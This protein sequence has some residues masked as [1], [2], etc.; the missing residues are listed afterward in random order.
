MKHFLSVLDWDRES[1]LEL[2]ERAKR[3]VPIAKAATPKSGG[4]H[5]MTALIL[6]KSTRTGGSY[7]EAWELLGNRVEYISGEDK[8][9][10]G[11][12]ESFSHTARTKAGQGAKILTIRAEFEGIARWLAEMYGKYNYPT[13]VHNA[14]D[15]S[16]EH[17]SQ[18]FLDVLTILLRLGRLENFTIGIVGD[19]KNSRTV[20]SLVRMLSLFA[21]IRVVLVSAPEVRLQP[22]YTKGLANVE[23][24]ESLDALVGCDIVYVTRVQVERFANKFDY[25]KV[26]GRYVVDR[27]VLDMLGPD[28]LIMHPLPNVDG[29]IATEILDHPQV[30]VDEQAENGTPMRMAMLDWSLLRLSHPWMPPT[31]EPQERVLGSRS[32]RDALARKHGESRYFTPIETGTVVDHLDPAMYTTIR[33]VLKLDASST[34]VV[35]SERLSSSRLSGGRK[36]AIVLEHRFLEK[37]EKAAVTVLSPTATF[38][39]LRDGTIVKS[40]MDALTAIQGIGRCPNPVCITRND[41]E[42]ARSSRFLIAND[43][44]GDL[45]CHYCEQHMKRDEVFVPS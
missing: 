34:P 25:Q 44:G 5:K 27:K 6:E 10:L 36:T 32:I 19:L 42:A 12:G 37:D 43:G 45:A 30:I 20:H 40:K 17:I 31:N 1:V 16:H 2:L 18:S 4:N 13:A 22:W 7:R 41:I 38:N 21:D 9:S 26:R 11:K 33:E 3:F 24:A 15:G 23:V 39:E 35:V 14:G 29:E 28:A 8:T